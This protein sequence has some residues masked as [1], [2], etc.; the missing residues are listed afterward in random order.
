L[1]TFIDAVLASSAMPAIFPYV[2][3]NGNTYMDGGVVINLDIASIVTRC[4]D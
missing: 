3:I 1:D 2:Q 4:N